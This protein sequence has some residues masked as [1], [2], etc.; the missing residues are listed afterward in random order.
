MTS[1]SLRKDEIFRA[2]QRALEDSGAVQGLDHQ[3]PVSAIAGR[4]LSLILYAALCVVPKLHSG[5]KCTVSG[6]HHGIPYDQHNARECI[7]PPVCVL[8]STTRQ[9]SF[10]TKNRFQARHSLS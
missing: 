7:H 10:T 9:V 1:P 8:N 6:S 3:G 2:Q 5:C 4:A